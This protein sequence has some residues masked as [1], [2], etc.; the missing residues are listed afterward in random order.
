MDHREPRPYH[1]LGDAV[2][3]ALTQGESDG[4]RRFLIWRLETG[5]CSP[6]PSRPNLPAT[7]SQVVAPQ[8][9]WESALPWVLVCR[10]KKVVA[11]GR[12]TAGVSTPLTIPQSPAINRSPGSPK[13][14]WLSATPWVW[15]LRKYTSPVD[16]RCNP[17]V[18]VP[19][20]LK[21]PTNGLSPGLPK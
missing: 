10:K 14:N 13:M 21:S 20:P 11:E 8:M 7:G 6:Y 12:N 17:T 2:G 1:S 9:N 3:R 4:S 5:D 18:S 15:V 19:S 16:S